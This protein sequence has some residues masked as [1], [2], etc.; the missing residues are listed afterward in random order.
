MKN[1]YDKLKGIT[2]K[3]LKDG[4]TAIYVR[5]KYLGK[6]YP[7]K[8]FTK[9]YGSSTKTAA[10][11]K[12]QKLKVLL[13]DGIDPFNTMGKSLN[14]YFY[15][16]LELNQQNGS[17]RKTTAD[18]YE[19]FY[20]GYIKKTIGHKKL[21]KINYVDLEKILENLNHTKG[22][23]KNRIYRILSPFFEES[24]KRGEIH[25]NPCKFLKYEQVDKKE[26]LEKRVV[27]DKLTIA[28]ILYVAFKNHR[29]R[30]T[31]QRD[32]LNIFFLMLL[33]TGHRQ[34]EIIQLKRDNCYLEEKKII[35]PK[36]ITKSKVDYDFP[37][38][39]ECIDWIKN[40]KDNEL[41]FPNMKLK[42]IYFNFKIY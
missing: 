36:S 14:D 29:A 24:I 1:S 18:Q 8:N 19:N 34:N 23:Y 7:V 42:S 12:L 27:E 40:K 20:D 16:S 37:I 10:Y 25:F 33:M 11:N 6:T 13:S 28:K 39:K 22:S 3:K 35:S 15:K 5:F 26:K 9:L 31:N 17:W 32:E 4:T 2:E 41:L 38:P 30:Y 21:D